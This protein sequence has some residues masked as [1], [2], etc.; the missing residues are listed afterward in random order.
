MSEGM[1]KVYLL[2]HL[3]ADAELRQSSNG[4]LLKLRLATTDSWLDKDKVRHERT[5]WHRI[6]LFG[7]RAEGLSRILTKGF[8]VL[9]VGRVSTSSYEKEGK[10]H[11]STEIVASDIFL[12]GGPRE[13]TSDR[14]SQMPDP[15][16]AHGA[17]SNGAMPHVTDPSS[18]YDQVP[19]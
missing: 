14:A 2:G 4:P 16:S 1:N 19:F 17:H 3:G 10:K 12:A 13:G 18:S 7:K 9:V 6:T 15:Y 8:Q 11:Y 5:E